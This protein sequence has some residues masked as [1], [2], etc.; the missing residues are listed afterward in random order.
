MVLF[1]K[2]KILQG[3]GRKQASKQAGI[4]DCVSDTRKTKNLKSEPY[5]RS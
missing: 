2:K 4:K 5:P 1:R 3:E